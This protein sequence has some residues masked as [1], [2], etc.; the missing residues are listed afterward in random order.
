MLAEKKALEQEVTSIMEATGALRHRISQ[1]RDEMEELQGH[2]S[3]G[4]SNV[5]IGK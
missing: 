3:E 5:D 1:M 2:E 4:S